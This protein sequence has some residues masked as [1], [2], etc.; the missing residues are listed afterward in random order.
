MNGAESDPVVGIRLRLAINFED[1]IPTNVLLQILR[2]TEAGLAAVDKTCF[3]D[4]IR[5]VGVSDLPLDAAR[6]R[7]RQH[8]NQRLWISGCEAGSIL[9]DGDVLVLAWVILQNTLGESLKEA[10]R[11]SGTHERLTRY[12]RNVME[13]TP[14]D[15]I[16]SLSQKISSAT[17]GAATV[18]GSEVERLPDGRSTATVKVD[19]D[20]AANPQPRL[21]D[22]PEENENEEDS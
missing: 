8:R 11:T 17:K 5:Y 15:M 1:S 20:P 4:A 2:G 21:Q 3:D 18:T 7:M 16:R 14:G 10:Y 6:E 22:P 19:V 13:R 12:F 9:F